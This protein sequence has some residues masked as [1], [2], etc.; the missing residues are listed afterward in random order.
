[1]VIHTYTVILFSTSAQQSK[2][3]STHLLTK[4]GLSALQ[5]KTPYVR[6]LSP[7]SIMLKLHINIHK[8]HSIQL[9][10][11]PSEASSLFLQKKGLTINS[12]ST[13][14]TITTPI[15]KINNVNFH[16]N[17]TH[18]ASCP[19]HPLFVVYKI[20]DVLITPKTLAVFYKFHLK[21]K[22]T[23]KFHEAE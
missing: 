5:N 22:N 23:K 7:M 18:I 19:P 3:D 8:V 13:Q 15:H 17:C 6:Q 1:M 11:S 14:N 16:A 12:H 10:T 9:L 21:D 4:M 20:K 2:N